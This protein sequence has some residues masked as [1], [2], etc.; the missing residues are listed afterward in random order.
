MEHDTI[1]LVSPVCSNKRESCSCR[2][3]LFKNSIN[4]FVD[5]GYGEKHVI[6]ESVI[7]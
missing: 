5:E 2:R 3:K 7:T 1:F 4:A 6:L